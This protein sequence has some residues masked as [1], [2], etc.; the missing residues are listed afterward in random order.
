MTLS[1][2]VA[3]LV[4]L[5]PLVF[6]GATLDPTQPLRFLVLSLAVTVLSAFL[7]LKTYRGQGNRET[8]VLRLLI[9]PVCGAY[10]LVTAMSVLQATNFAE[11]IYDLSKVLLMLIMLI[12]LVL[13]FISDKSSLR[14]VTRALT[15]SGGILAAIGVSQYYGIAFTNIPGNVIP[16][17]TMANKNLLACIVCLTLPFSVYTALREQ[18]LWSVIGGVVS[19]LSLLVVVLSQTRAAW[20]GL[21]IA[22]TVTGVVYAIWIR[23]SGRFRRTRR[24]RRIMIGIGAVALLIIL[25][26]AGSGIILREG[27][28]S[29]T[30]KLVSIFTHQD[31]SSKIRLAVWHKSWELC[32]QHPLLGVGVG[33]WK[34]VCPGLGFSGTLAETANLYFQQPHNDYLWVFAE[35][36]ILG[37]I[38]YLSLFA[39]S[40]IYSLR[41]VIRHSAREEA[42]SA[43]CLLF[44]LIYYLVDSFFS[45]PRE[46]IEIV[47]FLTL[48]L[49]CIAV[50][51]HWLE[52]SSHKIPRGI[53][54]S[55]LS[56]CFVLSLSISLL[57]VIRFNGETHIKRLWL[58]KASGN[59][60]EVARQEEL[61]RSRWLTLDPTGAPLAWYGGVAHFSL[62]QQQRACSD[63][64]Q[65]YRDNPNHPHVLNNLGTCAELSGDHRMAVEYYRHA[66]TVAAEFNEAWLNLSAAYYNLGEYQQ[67]DS[68]LSQVAPDYKDTR[69]TSFRQM[70]TDKIKGAQGTTGN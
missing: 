20:L 43:L 53:L 56:A 41:I 65:A 64:A 35:T 50:L 52:P 48:I 12:C 11:A 15:L 10:A 60:Q 44:A 47:F 32:Q 8:S 17:G 45:Y 54:M 70:I 37:I 7:L 22:T 61:A 29:I 59:W 62:G 42:L 36:G 51:H 69:V 31:S 3:T 68:A 63:F 24:S 57:G 1:I 19:L 58:A 33:N 5:L 4:I 16:Y 40:A 39:L 18:R 23:K 2:A 26:A 34:V 46:R 55:V 25:I 28:T 6:V 9:F 30:E 14:I 13:L 49:A 21:V 66:V 27:Q 38:L 67:A